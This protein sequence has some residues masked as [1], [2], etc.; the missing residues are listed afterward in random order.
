[1]FE[2][3]LTEMVNIKGESTVNG[4]KCMM[5]KIRSDS[6]TITIPPLKT[7]TTGARLKPLR[8]AIVENDA[9]TGVLQEQTVSDDMSWVI[10]ESTESVQTVMGGMAEAAAKRTIVSIAAVLG[11]AGGTLAA[12]EALIFWTVDTKMPCDVALKTTIHCRC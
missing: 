11:V 5:E 10:A 8:V 4:S 9:T 2:K 6:H 7:C 3:N 12:I 1:M